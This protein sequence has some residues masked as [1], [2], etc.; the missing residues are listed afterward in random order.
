MTESADVPHPNRSM[1][2]GCHLYE[3]S[4]QGTFSAN[5]LFF[6]LDGLRSVLCSLAQGVRIPVG[7]DSCVCRSLADGQDRDRPCGCVRSSS[8]L[9]Q[10]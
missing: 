2:R 9:R 6:R 4:C 3:A 8:S 7:A 5:A 10:S 1:G